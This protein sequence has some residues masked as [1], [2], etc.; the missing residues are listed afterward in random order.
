MKLDWRVPARWSGDEEEGLAAGL[1]CFAAYLG[2]VETAS[3]DSEQRFGDLFFRADSEEEVLSV[4]EALRAWCPSLQ[5]LGVPERLSA[6]DWLISWREQAQPF[7][8]GKSFWVDPREGDGVEA[9]PQPEGRTLL[10]LPARQAFGTGSHPST[11]LAAEWLEELNCEGLRLLDVGVG[12]GILGW[13]AKLKGAREVVGCDL[14]PAA[15]CYAQWLIRRERLEDFFVFCGSVW[16]L[17]GRGLGRFDLAVANVVPAELEP[18]L[19]ALRR[20][21]RPGGYLL[22]SGCLTEQEERWASTLRSSGFG[23]VFG[24]RQEGEW[25]AM[26]F[27]G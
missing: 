13:I 22:V 23:R 21:L 7:P 19:P 24:R 10:R 12:T 27:Q 9:V 6:K 1:W 20:C 2:L 17:G 26:L 4:L 14:D 15:A 25:L 16:C 5:Y 8:L 3:R 11:R 18:D